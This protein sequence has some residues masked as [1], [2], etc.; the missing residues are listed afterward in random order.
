MRAHRNRRGSVVGPVQR[1]LRLQREAEECGKRKSEA[2]QVRRG[3]GGDY[4]APSSERFSITNSTRR[5]R[6]Q[7][8]SLCSLHTGRVSP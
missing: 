7:H 3:E 1:W 5:L 4:F 8:S 6:D 2:G